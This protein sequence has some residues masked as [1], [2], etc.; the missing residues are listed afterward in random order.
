MTRLL[1]LAAAVAVLMTT[2]TFA[3]DCVDTFFDSMRRNHQE[4]PDQDRRQETNSQG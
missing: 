3:D 2:P 1:T 4:R